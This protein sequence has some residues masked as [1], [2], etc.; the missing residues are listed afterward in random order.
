VT[1]NPIPA[2][3]DFAPVAN[4]E[5]WINACIRRPAARS[6]FARAMKSAGLT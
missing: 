3:I 6:V 1:A 5:K 2:R 4:V